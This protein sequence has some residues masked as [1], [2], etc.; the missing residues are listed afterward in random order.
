MKFRFTIGKKL[1][2]GFG[3]L[4]LLTLLVF[5]IT[6]GTLD[7]SRDINP[8]NIEV[9]NPS[10]DKLQELKI[11]VLTSK[12]L[13]GNWVNIQKEHK[14]KDRLQELTSE[15]YQALKTQLDTL[16]H[17]WNKRN[18][19]KLVVLEG[20]IDRLFESH[21]GI[22]ET[23]VDFDTYEDPFIVFSANDLLKKAGK[24]P[25]A[26]IRCLPVWMS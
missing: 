7:S 9:N 24:L 23:L 6:Q 17:G 15:D 25:C 11:M 10:V 19:D 4:I 14:D 2:T 16:A 20:Q 8:R 21:K 1:G 26:P 13:I 3:V 18:Q 22:T 12:M 5:V